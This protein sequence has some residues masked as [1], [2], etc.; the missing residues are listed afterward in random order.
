M[1]KLT[2][3]RWELAEINYTINICLKEYFL[4]PTR[5]MRDEIQELRARRDA[6]E[7]DL[8]KEKRYG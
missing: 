5:I 1:D 8:Y 4:R 3:L 6:I 7:A 2:E